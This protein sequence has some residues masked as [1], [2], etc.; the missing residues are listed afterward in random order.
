MQKDLAFAIALSA[1][2]VILLL[3]GFFLEWSP[4]LLGLLIAVFVGSDGY[5]VVALVNRAKKPPVP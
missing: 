1:V 3:A 5:L 2:A 4:F